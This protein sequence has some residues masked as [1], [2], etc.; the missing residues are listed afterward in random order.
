MTF[1][2]FFVICYVSCQCHDKVAN[3]LTSALLELKNGDVL[4]LPNTR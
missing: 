4:L 3:V 1:D 2:H